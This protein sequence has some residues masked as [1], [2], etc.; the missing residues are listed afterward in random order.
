MSAGGD[1]AQSQV[2]TRQEAELLL[3]AL[4]SALDE[5]EGVLE[6]ETAL[7]GAGRL[8]DGLAE[9]GRKSELTAAYVLLLQRAKAN[10][11]VLARLVPEALGAF[12]SRQSAFERGMGRNPTVIAT[13]R[14]VSEGLI[15]GLS[16]AVQREA[17]PNAYGLPNCPRGNANTSASPLVFSGR[18]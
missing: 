2:A 8:R 12:R 14:A 3:A 16:E 18:F 15:R 6:S 13:A 4:T 17:R 5:L 7:I 9:E 10:V 11:V 1:V